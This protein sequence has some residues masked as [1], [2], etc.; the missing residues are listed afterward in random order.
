MKDKL[1]RFDN[2]PRPEKRTRT[3][4]TKVTLKR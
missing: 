4:T 1:G 3:N 2:R